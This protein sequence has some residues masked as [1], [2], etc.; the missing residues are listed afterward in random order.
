[1]SL[2]KRGA[3]WMLLFLMESFRNRAPQANFKI[4]CSPDW[5]CD[6]VVLSSVHPMAFYFVNLL[7]CIYHVSHVYH[8]PSPVCSALS[9]LWCWGHCVTF[10]GHYLFIVKWIA[11]DA[12]WNT[13][14]MGLLLSFGSMMC[15]SVIVH[16]LVL[17]LQALAGWTWF[18]NEIIRILRTLI[19]DFIY[20]LRDILVRF[21][22]SKMRKHGSVAQ[23][24]E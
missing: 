24:T 7:P 12:S 11:W 15:H 23:I 8:G 14:L 19:L 1:M 3:G 22:Y 16:S 18:P 6:P 20:I 9:L 4:Q 13:C 2:G 10:G 21:Y 5:T 17:D